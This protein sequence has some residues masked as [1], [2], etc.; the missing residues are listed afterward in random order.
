MTTLVDKKHTQIRNWLQK[1]ADADEMEDDTM[2][3]RSV[4]SRNA[5][6][7][8]ISWG[9]SFPMGQG[10]TVWTMM[11]MWA[12]R[13]APLGYIETPPGLG[14]GGTWQQNQCSFVLTD[15]GVMLLEEQMPYTNPTPPAIPATNPTS[16]M[17]QLGGTA[18]QWQTPH[19]T[20]PFNMAG[21]PNLYGATTDAQLTSGALINQQFLQQPA[22]R[23]FSHLPEMPTGTFPQLSPFSTTHPQQLP[24]IT[25][26]RSPERNVKREGEKVAEKEK[27]EK[28]ESRR[29]K[30]KTEEKRT[31]EPVVLLTEHTDKNRSFWMPEVPRI[32]PRQLVKLFPPL[33]QEGEEDPAANFAED[34]HPTRGM[35]W[36][37][38]GRRTISASR[39][40]PGETGASNGRQ[41]DNRF[42]TA[43]GLVLGAKFMDG[44]P[45][46]KAPGQAAEIRSW[47]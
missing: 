42:A 45:H 19:Q 41:T 46:R 30:R 1:V 24:P 22:T 36:Q 8:N 40:G 3:L 47:A 2:S 4:A 23:R 18:T 28:S 39:P 5:T 15:R 12:A 38:R 44:G 29:K 17:T 25:Q 9:M 31:V 34:H 11:G 27:I 13:Q 43:N 33:L 37:S 32:G 35:V 10:W 21:L 20:A 26:P 16:G 7:T 6:A 14:L